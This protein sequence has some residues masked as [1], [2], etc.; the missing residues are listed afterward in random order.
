MTVFPARFYGDPSNNVDENRRQEA[1][2]KKREARRKKKKRRRIRKL[3]EQ[4]IKNGG[5]K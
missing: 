3:T 1:M 5:I 4:A 2:D